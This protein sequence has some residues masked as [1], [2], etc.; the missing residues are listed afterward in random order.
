MVKLPK[1]ATARERCRDAH[2]E[3]GSARNAG[4]GAR[5][6]GSSRSNYLWYFMLSWL[7]RYLVDERGFSMHEME[8]VCDA[9]AI[10]STA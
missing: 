4:S 10:S 1:I 3:H 5:A 7:P 2:L 8:H 6:S 9:R